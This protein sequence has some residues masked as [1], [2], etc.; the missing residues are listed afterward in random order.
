MKLRS[1]Q[2][3]TLESIAKHWAIDG[4]DR[5]AVILPTGAGKTV[6]FSELSRILEQ[7]GRGRRTLILVH[8][9]EL[10]TQTVAKLQAMGVKSIGVVKGNQNEVAA[11]TIVAT[12]QTLY[13]N[14]RLA[15]LLDAGPIYRV[16]CDE[17]HHF[18]SAR[19]KT[20]LSRL[21]VFDGRTKAVGFTATFVRGDSA[22]LGNDW[23]VVYE[24]D[25]QW[26]IEHGYLSDV[27]AHSIRVPDLDLST[28][29]STAG[30]F[31]DNS[32]GTA[33]A[34]SSADEVIPIAWR[35]YAEGRPTILFAPNIASCGTLSQG[36]QA[37]GIKTEVVFGTTPTAER[38]AVYDRIRNG[39]T[40]VLASVGV[41]TEG[42]DIPA[43]S[44]AILARP[45]KSKGLWQQMA[46]RALRLFPGKDKAILLDITGD[47]EN[48][49]LASVT[50]LTETRQESET[51]KSAPAVCACFDSPVV[52]CCTPGETRLE[53][54]KNQVQGKCFCR[55]FCAVDFDDTE[56]TL[57]RGDHDVEVDLF[58]GS[59]SV[60]LQTYRGVWFVPTTSRLYFIARRPDVGGE[61]YW[62]GCSGT[63]QSMGG[64]AWISQSPLDM[65][66]AMALAQERAESE[67][68]TIARRDS[69]WRR[70][71]AGEGQLFKAAGLGIPVERGM[72]KGP[73]S[74]A[75]S[76]YYA[77]RM[78]DQKIG[79]F[80]QP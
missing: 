65:T 31:S 57:V 29:K 50:D 64:G 46:G 42:F 5:A 12:V 51:K 71:K 75:I 16:I 25:V 17:L 73:V 26:G 38:Q 74:D 34:N 41:L 8:R 60:W 39:T 4:Q 2:T 67:D 20:L 52:M 1:Y 24:R 11:T 58:A 44:C 19:N 80:I 47:A 28:V 32:L 72:R 77:S 63:G 37:A 14:R 13:H 9:E 21:G 69:K 35:K 22:K 54:R 66:M 27:E 79:H 59:T 53:C 7:H 48:H 62:I 78:L 70:T 33:M 30:D 18:A 6:I 40:Q 61:G 23:D 10:V 55:C 56:L 49:S 3:E 68:P 76:S 43:I 36:L 45:T 15:M